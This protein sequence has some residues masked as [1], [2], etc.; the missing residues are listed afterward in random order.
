MSQQQEVH[1]Q[2]TAKAAAQKEPEIGIK[3]R[4][5]TNEQESF[6]SSNLAAVMAREAPWLTPSQ[7]T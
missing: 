4:A 1:E 2:I 6:S 5:L 7:C 3:E